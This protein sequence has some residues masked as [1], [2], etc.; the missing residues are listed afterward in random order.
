LPPAPF[1]ALMIS[2]AHSEKDLRNTIAAFES[3]AA[4]EQRG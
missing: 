2:L 1:E 3:W 4:G